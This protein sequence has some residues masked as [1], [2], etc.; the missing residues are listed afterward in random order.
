MA[1]IRAM[2][3]VF[4]HP[5]KILISA[6][7]SEIGHCLGAA[8]GI[9]A[10][11]TLMTIMHNRVPPTINLEDP[12]PELGFTAPTVAVEHEINTAISNSFGFG[13]HNATLIFGKY[14]S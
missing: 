4:A 5:E 3:Q 13:G 2:K 1:E 8:G 12:E 11:A 14:K 6:T 10:I 9:E 7:K